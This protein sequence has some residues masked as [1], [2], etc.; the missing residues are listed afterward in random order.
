MANGQIGKAVAGNDQVRLGA[1]ASK[2]RRTTKVIVAA[3]VIL[4]IA[5]IVA[6]IIW[7]GAI[8][9]VDVTDKYA[10][11]QTA[12]IDLDNDGRDE[13]VTVNGAVNSGDQMSGLYENYEIVVDSDSWLIDPATGSAIDRS[14]V[15]QSSSDVSDDY[16]LYLYSWA[17]ADLNDDEQLEIMV[18]SANMMEPEPSYPKYY[19]FSYKGDGD[20]RYMGH[21][22][23]GEMSYDRLTGVLRSSYLLGG[24]ESDYATDQLQLPS[25]Q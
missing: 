25:Q 24:A 20:L 19:I 3:I 2:A 5:A 7:R 10:I 23:D 14:N 21:I 12:R 17:V 6:V 16:R 1:R 4:V 11:S 8:V 13:T 9:R 18:R 15:L 22:K